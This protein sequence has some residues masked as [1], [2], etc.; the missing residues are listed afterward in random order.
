MRVAGFVC[1]GWMCGSSVEIDSKG[2]IVSEMKLVSKVQFC[3]GRQLELA[4][5]QSDGSSGSRI[6]VAC[7]SETVYQVATV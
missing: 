4:V 5:Q 1:K 6:L 3:A 2:Q 7:W